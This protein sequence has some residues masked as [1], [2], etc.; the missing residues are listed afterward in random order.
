[1]S[2]SPA[3]NNVLRL[4]AHPR[5]PASMQPALARFTQGASGFG[6][7]LPWVEV[8]D[9]ALR[10]VELTHEEIDLELEAAQAEYKVAQ[11]EP[12]R[13]LKRQI[14][15]PRTQLDQQRNAANQAIQKVYS[16]WS[17]RLRQRFERARVECR[18]AM[19]LEPVEIVSKLDPHLIL[20]TAAWSRF[21]DAVRMHGQRAIEEA[22]R[23]IGND[24][25]TAL[26]RVTSI[27]G[28][29]ALEPSGLDLPPIDTRIDVVG[30]LPRKELEN[31]HPLAA[32]FRGLRG[33]IGTIFFLAMIIGILA[34]PF[35]GAQYDVAAM[36]APLIPWSANGEPKP[37]G[38]RKPIE[39][40]NAKLDDGD[41]AKMIKFWL[42]AV[43]IV[44][45]LAVAYTSGRHEVR[46]LRHKASEQWKT[47]AER[48]LEQKAQ[49]ALEEPAQAMARWLDGR[50]EQ[51]TFM[52]YM[53]W[54]V[55]VTPALERW[56]GEVEQ[57]NY[58]RMSDAARRGSQVGA[59]QTYRGQLQTLLIELSQKR[60][61]LALSAPS[62]GSA[63][64]PKPFAFSLSE[65]A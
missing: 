39:L 31:V 17:V 62:P 19:T 21:G 51:A 18:G 20:S 13:A 3:L 22:Q 52:V 53:W 16:D 7:T 50:R 10:L 55:D 26:S 2:S 41:P 5:T 65:D 4:A 43:C 8:Y 42:I 37:E 44:P 46:K 56:Q 34:A 58:G 40:K 47:E 61:E 48:A 60:G 9:S 28:V 1:M 23:E 33:S 57:D 38:E 63:S 11:D 32:A 27:D 45:L 6:S 14:E 49:A 30:P 35:S 54:N 25:R 59:L 36:T 15:K 64:A 29:R 12:G 24:L